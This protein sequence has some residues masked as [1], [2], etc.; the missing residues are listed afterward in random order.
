MNISLKEAVEKIEEAKN[1]GRVF[2]VTFVKRTNGEIR[3]MN[4]RGGVSKGVSGV[5]RYYDPADHNLISV[6]DMKVGAFRHINCNTITRVT[7]NGVT[8]TVVQP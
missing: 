2:S 3:D 7:A 6:F 5:G 8:F 4:C 1:S